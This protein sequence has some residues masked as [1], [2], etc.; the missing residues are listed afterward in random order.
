MRARA[1]AS[2][3]RSA[4][5]SDIGRRAVALFT[6][7]AAE[8]PENTLFPNKLPSLHC[9]QLASLALRTDF[10]RRIGAGDERAPN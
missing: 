8:I 1:S 3:A 4:D 5:C 2:C 7:F 6:S 10:L 9:K